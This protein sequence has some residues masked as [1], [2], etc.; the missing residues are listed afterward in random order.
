MKPTTVLLLAA[1][2]LFAAPSTTIADDDEFHPA[3]KELAIGQIYKIAQNDLLI[4]AVIEHNKKSKSYKQAQ[5]DSMD[6]QWRE[7]IGAGDQPLIESLLSTDVSRYLKKVQSESRGLF[8]EIFI[9]DK[10]GINVAQSAITSDYWQGDEEHWIKSYKAGTN[11]I[12]IGHMHVDE[13]TQIL[14]S[15]ISIPIVD[16]WGKPIGAITFGVD[17]QML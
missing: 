12:A 10:R 1:S 14:Q 8:T 6:R 3:L 13:S 4:D 9:M 17:V 16:N 5:I 7:E 2:I 15:H 11:S